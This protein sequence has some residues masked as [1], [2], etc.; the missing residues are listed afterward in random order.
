[1]PGKKK[2]LWIV[3]VSDERP[4]KKVAADLRAAGFDVDQILEEVGTITGSAA[5]DKVPQLRKIQGV[6]DVSPDYPVKIS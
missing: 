2:E 5:P 1:M 4:I 3:T 6:M